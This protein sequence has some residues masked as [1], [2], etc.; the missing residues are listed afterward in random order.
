VLRRFRAGT[1]LTFGINGVDKIFH[2][3][4][5]TIVRDITVIASAGRRQK[6]GTS[7]GSTS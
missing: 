5:A 6:F 7:S 2:D 3:A 1:F 4:S